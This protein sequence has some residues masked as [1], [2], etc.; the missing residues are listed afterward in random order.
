MLSS[1]TL[2]ERPGTIPEEWNL[3]AFTKRDPRNEHG[4]ELRRI[5]VEL[6][7]YEY[8]DFDWRVFR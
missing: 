2:A 3:D 5:G 8:E 6:G 4:T 1:V 7:L